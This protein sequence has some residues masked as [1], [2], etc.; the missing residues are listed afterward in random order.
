MP[1][2]AKLLTT[3]PDSATSLFI[4][5]E[6]RIRQFSVPDCTLLGFVEFTS[7][8][9]H[10]A[11]GRATDGGVLFAS[12]RADE[13]TISHWETPEI[14]ENRNGVALQ[15]IRF[16]PIDT[17]GT[18]HLLGYDGVF[19]RVFDPQNLEES[20][21]I[22]AGP[23]L[24][25]FSTARL[26]SGIEL[27]LILAYEWNNGV[28]AK[29]IS[30][31]AQLFEFPANNLARM[32]VA[33]HDADSFDE[34]AFADA[35]HGGIHILDRS[36]AEIFF[37]HNPGHGVAALDFADFQRDGTVEIA[38]VSL[39]ENGLH[40]T[41]INTP[42]NSGV[43]RARLHGYFDGNFHR[44]DTHAPD[45]FRYAYSSN[46]WQHGD[47]GGVVEIDIV[48]GNEIAHWPVTSRIQA[49]ASIKSSEWSQPGFCTFGMD[50]TDGNTL[51]NCHA[52]E[53]QNVQ[54]LWTQLPND[55]F[56]HMGSGD[57]NGDDTDDLVIVYG[58]GQVDAL[59]GLDGTLIW[60]TN[61]G[62]STSEVNL[63][64]E[65]DQGPIWIVAPG[66]LWKL[67]PSDGSIDN[68][69][70]FQ[71]FEA[72]AQIDKEIHV[73]KGGRVGV[74][75]PETLEISSTIAE[76]EPHQIVSMHALPDEQ[77]LAIVHR[78]SDPGLPDFK[79]SLLGLPDGDLLASAI[80]PASVTSTYGRYLHAVSLAGTRRFRINRS[81]FVF[82]DGFESGSR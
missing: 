46:A 39:G 19:V 9:D 7:P 63:L 80:W 62:V 73:A 4:A 76:F 23:G 3:A 44:Q 61:L 24:R 40:W 35:Q 65:P 58:S 43:E 5:D 59:S 36:G 67:D 57:V 2:K 77:V 52:I 21:S 48:S 50:V 74:L 68:A 26:E 12:S 79:I 14:A 54:N 56:A 1:V 18:N 8:A 47:G 71:N 25:S 41:S 53:G 29:Q 6:N 51:I 82:S 64:I 38:W 22:F 81:D 34:I 10:V 31:G 28:V 49:F 33:D 20:A 27:A 72:L 60:S 15:D 37:A 30:S 66:S 75:D 69:G 13:L 32:A 70:L 55:L 78:N 45:R 17:T 11:L 42:A 16:L